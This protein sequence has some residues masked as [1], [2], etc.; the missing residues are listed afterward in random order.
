MMLKLKN[1]KKYL[2]SLAEAK[3]AFRFHCRPLENRKRKD[4]NPGLLYK[5]SKRY[6]SQ[7]DRMRV[8]LEKILKQQ[9]CVFMIV[10]AWE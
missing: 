4:L 8:E 5:K 2:V 7:F 10:D 3:Q 1:K 6:L 9:S